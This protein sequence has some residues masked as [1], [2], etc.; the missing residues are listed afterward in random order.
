[1]EFL[2]CWI[3]HILPF[4]EKPK[5]DRLIQTVL[6]EVRRTSFIDMMSILSAIIA[7][8]GLSPICNQQSG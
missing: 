5:Q 3:T 7:C 2:G 4:I 8:F 1:M 6:S